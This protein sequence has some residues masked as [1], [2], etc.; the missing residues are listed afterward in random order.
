MGDFSAAF[1]VLLKLDDQVQWMFHRGDLPVTLAPVLG[2]IVDPIRQRQV[3]TMAARR[4]LSVPEI[5]R[6]VDR[7]AGALQ[8]CA[9]NHLAAGRAAQAR[10]EP[11][12]RGGAG[13]PGGTRRRITLPRRAC[14]PV[15]NYLLRVRCGGPS[16]LLLGLPDARPRQPRARSHRTPVSANRNTLQWRSAVRVCARCGSRRIA[17]GYR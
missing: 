2:K 1:L 16:D 9:A 5:E 15:R 11:E 3:A 7:G 14:R 10:P 4:Q 12:P 13:R 8:V 6:I 17:A